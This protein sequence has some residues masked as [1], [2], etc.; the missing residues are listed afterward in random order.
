MTTY[1]H[2]MIIICEKYMEKLIYQNL[3][4]ESFMQ[5]QSTFSVNN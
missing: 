2:V 4:G 5:S 1:T 3:S